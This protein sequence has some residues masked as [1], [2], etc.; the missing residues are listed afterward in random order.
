MSIINLTE[1]LKYFKGKE[2]TELSTMYNNETISELAFL[3]SI[4]RDYIK[5]FKYNEVIRGFAIQN[6]QIN[7]S[8]FCQFN[9]IPGSCV[10]NQQLL[11]IKSSQIITHSIDITNYP[12]N[13][14]YIYV[15]LESSNNDDELKL[16]SIFADI[17]GNLYPTETPFE[18]TNNHLVIG[19]LKVKVVESVCILQNITASFISKFVNIKNKNILVYKS[20]TEI[21]S[22]IE[23]I[24][25]SDLMTPY[26]TET[27]TLTSDDL[28]NGYI[29]TSRQMD[30]TDD[31]RIHV[32]SGSLLYP[33]T[34]FTI[35][36]P[37]IILLNP[38][39]PLVAGDILTLYYYTI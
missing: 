9:I 14:G 30:T 25:T 39:L 13:N 12:I 11:I 20:L 33:P 7:N 26:E 35:Q 1:N 32:L 6:L 29:L 36:P 8:G 15:V 24:A 38:A 2:L 19:V 22:L 18:V 16:M 4:L 10:L 27:Y 3:P 31:V 34:D 37:N 28:T 17:D 5:S 21:L 23:P